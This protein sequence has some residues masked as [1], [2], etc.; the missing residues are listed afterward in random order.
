MS[1]WFHVSGR[2]SRR[3]FWQDYLWPLAALFI[4]G[5]MLDELLFTAGMAMPDPDGGLVTS[6][7]A[8]VG[9]I[10]MGAAAV[11][12]LHDLGISGGWLVLALG[13]PVVGPLLA[14]ALLGSLPGA[15]G[16]NRFG[17]RPP[18]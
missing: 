8:I 5:A 3:Q 15:P 13:T 18:A 11:K 1:G 4:L 6:L 2:I 12:R 10:G 9:L 17:P 16:G 14:V 7:A